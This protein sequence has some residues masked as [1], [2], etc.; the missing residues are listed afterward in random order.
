MNNINLILQNFEQEQK[1]TLEKTLPK[2]NYGDTIRVNCKIIEGD[3]ERIQAFE[4]LCIAIKNKGV[5]STFVIRKISS[6]IGIE[7]TF[8]L[9]SPMI[10]GIEIV[11]RGIVRRAK[12]YYMRDLRGKAARI[13]E[14]KEF[15]PKVAKA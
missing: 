3:K 5:R 15:A 13:K 12:L 7:R 11:K 2:F 9:H 1:A 6:G 8:P 10:D 14:R 4:G